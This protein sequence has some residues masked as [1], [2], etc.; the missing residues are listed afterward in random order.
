MHNECSISRRDPM[1]C[2]DI[3]ITLR[4]YARFARPFHDANL[5]AC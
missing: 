3:R 2:E 4:F 1:T 5:A